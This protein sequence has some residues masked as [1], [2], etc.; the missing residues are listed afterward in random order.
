MEVI[1]SLILIYCQ[2]H[3]NYKGCYDQHL[4]CV[5]DYIVKN[6]NSD[7]PRKPLSSHSEIL[8]NAYLTC[9]EK[10]DVSCLNEGY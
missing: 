8:A 9:T 1:S 4:W 6:S 7:Y 10:T 2:N 5:K 3:F